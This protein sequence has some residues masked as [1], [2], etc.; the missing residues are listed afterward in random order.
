MDIIHN[1]RHH[2]EFGLIGGIPK[3]ETNDIDELGD[4]VFARVDEDG[5]CGDVLV[6]I[7]K[8]VLRNWVGPQDGVLSGQQIDIPI[9]FIFA[10]S[11]ISSFELVSLNLLDI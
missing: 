10:T 6:A 9:L 7:S 3:V 4:L 5:S 1:H 2:I 11:E 8:I